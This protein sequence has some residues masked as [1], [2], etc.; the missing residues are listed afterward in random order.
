MNDPPLHAMVFGKCIMRFDRFLD[1]VKLAADKLEAENRPE[2]SVA[3]FTSDMLLS[4][5]IDTYTWTSF[6]RL[7]SSSLVDIIT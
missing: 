7:L 1:G 6:E 5:T 2:S 4:N 3:T